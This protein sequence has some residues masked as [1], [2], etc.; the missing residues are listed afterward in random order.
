MEKYLDRF[1]RL[2]YGKN[3]ELALASFNEKAVLTSAADLIE[4]LKAEV[5]RLREENRSLRAFHNRVHEA[6]NSGDG[7]YRP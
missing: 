6:L 1:L 2:L 5:E 4:E 7:V 3:V